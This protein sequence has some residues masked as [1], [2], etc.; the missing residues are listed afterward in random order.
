[1]HIKGI[2]TEVGE[3]A[4]VKVR[5]PE[6]DDTVTD[7]LPVAQCL[8][9]DA[10][11]YAV[12]RVNT[13]VIILPGTGLEDAVV[14]GAIYSKPDPAPFDDAAIIGMVAREPW[15]G[16]LWKSLPHAQVNHRRCLPGNSE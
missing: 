11:C 2:V 7:W 8:T 15:S 4:R 10:K 12:P 13:Q 9:F 6:F 16:R 14:V 5:L 1:M 3:N